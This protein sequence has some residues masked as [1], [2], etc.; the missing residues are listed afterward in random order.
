MQWLV[1]W[2]WPISENL[3]RSGGQ[4]VPSFFLYN[5][6][7]DS[8][9]FYIW[10]KIFIYNIIYISNISTKSCHFKETKTVTELSDLLQIT[11]LS[12]D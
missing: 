2:S 5:L 1:P 4:G 11:E 8:P 9:P 7:P 12:Q 10:L 3:Q 6:L